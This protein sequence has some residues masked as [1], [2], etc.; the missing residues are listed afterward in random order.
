M[1]DFKLTVYTDLNDESK[2]M[3]VLEACDGFIKIKAQSEILEDHVEAIDNL[4]D[5][6]EDFLDELEISC[7]AL[8][9]S[10][11]VFDKADLV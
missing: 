7:N 10:E 8:K 9:E 11:V 1:K 4:S 5:K 2:K 3:A 6:L